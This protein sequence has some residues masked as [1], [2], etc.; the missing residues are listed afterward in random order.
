MNKV[1]PYSILEYRIRTGFYAQ[2]AWLAPERELS[3]ELGVHRQAIRRAV[4]RLSE[5]GLLERRAGHRPIVRLPENGMPFPRTVAFLMGNEPLFHAFQTVLKGCEPEIVEAGYRLV[6]MDTH[7]AT[8]EASTEI[9]GNALDNLLAHP[10]AGLVIWCQNVV[11]SL[12]KLQALQ[13]A[14]TVIVCIDRDVPGLEADF[15]G[16]DNQDASRRAVE[17][18]Y[19][20]G[21]RRIAL[22]TLD[23]YTSAVVERERGFHATVNRLGLKSEDCPLIRITGG[24]LNPVEVVAEVAHRILTHP[25]RP[26]A[27]FAVNDILAWRL[28]RAVNE[29]GRSVPGDLAIIGFDDIEPKAMHKPLLTTM[30]QPFERIGYYAARMFLERMRT[31]SLPIRHVLLDTPLVVRASTASDP[32][33]LPEPPRDPTAKENA[34]GLATR[35][36]NAII[37]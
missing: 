37:S 34:D 16:V 36:S 32:D 31:P 26:T 13:K 3:R 19:N 14:G 2:G 22:F 28:L 1:D 8:N 7:A 24:A 25:N 27:V 17:H 6:F 23:E 10:V 5:A 33:L 18:L 21:H 9:E 35:V 15:V 20:I 12:P 30:R 11:N 4:A 29:S